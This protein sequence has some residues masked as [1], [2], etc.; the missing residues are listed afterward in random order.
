MVHDTVQYCGG[1]CEDPYFFFEVLRNILVPK[2]IHQEVVR[3][4]VSVPFV[5]SWEHG[6]LTEESLI[7]ESY[8]HIVKGIVCM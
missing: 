5:E 7:Y 4:G 2:E 6:Q 3:V 8:L 1:F